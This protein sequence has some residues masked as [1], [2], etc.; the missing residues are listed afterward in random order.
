MNRVLLLGTIALAALLSGCPATGVGDPCVPQHPVFTGAP[1]EHVC[2][3][4][5]PDSACFVG[6]EVYI[7]TRSLQCR[8][9]VC[10]VYHWDEFTNMDERNR[11]VYCTCRC[12]GPGDPSQLCQCPDQ[13]VCNTVFVAG[14]P[15]IQGAYCIRSDTAGDGGT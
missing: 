10:M 12:G 3:A 15:G 11:R 8:T 6:T 14:E 4:G 13:Y 2:P 5:G 1:G 9:R 7:E